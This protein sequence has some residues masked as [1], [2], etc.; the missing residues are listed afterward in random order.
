ML[1]A[2][3]RPTKILTVFFSTEMWE[4]Y[5]FYVVQAL[6]ALYLSLHLGI[7]DKQT[8][9]LVGSFTA[10]TYISPIIGGWI[11][12][13]FLGQ[14]VSV[15][16]GAVFLF[17]SYVVLA[18]STNLHHLLLSL[19]MIATGTGLLK[20]NVSALLGKQYKISDPRRDS[21]FTIFYLGITTGIILGTTLPSQL[22]KAFGWSTCFISAAIGL[23]LAFLVFYFGTRVLKVQEYSTPQRGA[24]ANW[25]IAGGVLFLAYIVFFFVLN[26]PD[27][28]NFFFGGVVLIS[29]GIVLRIAYQEQSEQ[30]YKTLSLLLLFVISVFF[31]SFYFEMF[32]A[33]TLFITRAVQPIVFG[34]H[35]PAPYYVSVQ[36]F[37]MIIFGIVLARFWSTIRYKNIAHAISI[38]FMI[39]MLCM[40]AAYT[41]ILF[42]T[43]NVTSL[44]LISA[45]PILGAYLMISLAELMLSPIG[46]SAVTQLSSEHVV[47]T[48]MG[49]FF[50][51]LGIGGFLSGQLAKLTAID[52]KTLSLVQVKTQYLHGFEIL[53]AILVG[54]CVIT[55][56]L[57]WI[58]KK[59][60]DKVDWQDLHLN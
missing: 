55:A 25:S 22:Q 59:F 34:I 1:D 48:L 6:L 27:M 56:I 33:L 42:S 49:V 32:M 5:G 51:S 47:S 9:M 20:P 36:S 52:D 24:I 35:F 7:G 23:I 41:I 29:V 54:A 57:C 60:S 14:R 44:A 50:V 16:A 38:K 13:N 31:W 39:S 15:L 21:G 30:R 43:S 17:C 40:L 37:G 28:A 19:A 46:L 3:S 26:N 53:I 10:L 8:Y 58:I 11:A 18:F 4:R 2:I 45:V 12:D